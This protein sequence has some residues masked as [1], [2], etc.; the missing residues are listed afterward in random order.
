MPVSFV[1]GEHDWMQPSAGQRVA[2][3]TASAR[4]RLTPYDCKVRA[5]A[6][7]R[8]MRRAR[9][10]GLLHRFL[11]SACTRVRAKAGLSL[12][13]A[14]RAA[15]E[16]GRMTLP[17]LRRAGSPRRE[18]GQRGAPARRSA[19]A[20]QGAVGRLSD[21]RMRF[22]PGNSS[23]FWPLVNQVTIARACAGGHR[24]AGRALPI[25]G[26]AAGVPGPG[27]AA[28]GGR[29]GRQ[30]GCGRRARGRG[31]CH[32]RARVL[33]AAD[34]RVAG[35]VVRRRAAAAPPALESDAL[36]PSPCAASVAGPLCLLCSAT[37][38]PCA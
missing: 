36:A 25:P 12:A 24:A 23:H 37:W 11:C 5:A 38:V 35:P 34:L 29:G 16:P 21:A 19:A 3:A 32:A 4:G 17:T 28:D 6:D 14:G 20:G 27:A 26:P 1:Y 22:N 15:G 7:P 13:R 10:A 8:R 2:A 31:G 9:P 18:R 30:R 33:A